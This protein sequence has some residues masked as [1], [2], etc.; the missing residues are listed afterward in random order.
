MSKRSDSMSLTTKLLTKANGEL[1]QNLQANQLTPGEYTIQFCTAPLTTGP[2]P[3]FAQAVVTWK[4]GGQQLVRQVT[5]NDGT[6]LSGNC[7]AVDVKIKDVTDAFGGIVLGQEY[8]VTA[9]LC[10]GSRPAIEQ[11]PVLAAG[12]TVILGAGSTAVF[13]I[14]QRV[15]VTSYKVYGTSVS[16]PIANRSLYD[17][18]SICAETSGANNSAYAYPL[19]TTSWSPITAGA[20]VLYVVNRAAFIQNIYVMWGIEG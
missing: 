6:V 17:L 1:L 20:N 11:P 4:V 13:P 18:I 9:T 7:E 12:S 19:L 10:P 14:P 2:N 8:E 16:E 5:V 15:G 3:F